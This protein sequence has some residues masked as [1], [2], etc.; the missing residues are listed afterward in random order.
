[1]KL[2]QRHL[3]LCPLTLASILL[4]AAPALAQT[5]APAAVAPPTINVHGY[6]RVRVMSNFNYDLD[7]AAV[8]DNWLFFTDMRGWLGVE[9]GWDRAKLVVSTD[10]AGTDFDEGAIMGFDSSARQRPMQ[11]MLR[12]LYLDYAMPELGMTAIVGRQP[13]RLG[14]GLVSAINRDAFKL[15]RALGDLGPLAKSAL[16][17]SAIRGGKGNTLWPDHLPAPSANVTIQK[18]MSGAVQGA[19]ITNDPDGSWHELGTY[20]L[21][22]SAAPLGQ[23]VQAFFAQQIDMSQAAVYPSKRY[24]DINGDTNIGPVAMGLEGV[25]LSG[26]GPAAASTGQRP[27]L[28]SYAL[29]GTMRYTHEALD[30]GFVV[31]RG[32][33]D[34]DAT[35][36]VN[37]GF[38]S[39][40]ID[41][42]SPAYNQLFGDD[43]HGFD[44]TD[45][46]I[47][48]G[49]GL[50]NVTFL[51][52]NVTW[53]LSP[54]VT[55][56]LGYTYH[57]ASVPQRVGAGVMGLAP[58]TNTDTTSDIGSELDARVSWKIG[59]TNLYGAAA[60]FVPGGIYA[61]PGF[62]NAAHKLEIGTEVKF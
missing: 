8:T 45:A 26:V 20:V 38:Q 18:G 55:A 5:P 3:F 35:D 33:G 48:R 36:N 49:A 52:P 19:P 4:T 1:M 57:L 61:K 51:Q 7:A 27:D 21:A 32:G 13:A 28:R 34:N 25:W 6:N 43:I 60:T 9:A 59:P 10:L 2:K 11:V 22:Y 31:G 16:T 14:L 24:L 17:V 46:S 54:D 50:N 12:H 42:Q 56:N 15:T 30:F 41:E 29:F 40:F 62:A 47:G 58:T 39:L 44:G 37:N 53:H 23:R